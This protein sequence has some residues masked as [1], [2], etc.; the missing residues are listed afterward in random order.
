MSLIVLPEQNKNKDEWC[1]ENGKECIWYDENPQTGHVI[2]TSPMTPR[3]H[4]YVRH[5]TTKPK[6]M[7]RVFRK[8]HVQE[9]EKNEDLIR[10]IWERGKDK[11]EALRSRLYQRLASADCKEWEKSFIREALQRM[12]DRDF[13]NQKNTLYGVSAMEEQE[14]PVPG[15]RTKVTVEVCGE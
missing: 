15:G 2:L 5:R 12:A 10:R 8:L 14:A 9:R 6:E 13:E 1:F 3:R 4:G 7:D 11:Y